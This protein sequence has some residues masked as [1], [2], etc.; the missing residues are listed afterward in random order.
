MLTSTSNVMVG[1]RIQVGVQSMERSPQYVEFLGRLVHMRMAKN[2]WFD[3]PFTREESILMSEK[4]KLTV[5]CE[6]FCTKLRIYGTNKV[7][8]KDTLNTYY[9][10]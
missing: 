3:I 10:W 1:M 5:T 8:L 9:P 7:S 4:N 2:R 6:Y